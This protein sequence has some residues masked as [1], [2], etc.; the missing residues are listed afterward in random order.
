MQGRRKVCEGHDFSRVERV[1]RY[2]DILG[3]N[4]AVTGREQPRSVA[5]DFDGGGGGEGDRGGFG[6]GDGDFGEGEFFEAGSCDEGGEGFE[7]LE[8]G[9]FDDL[10]QGRALAGLVG[11]VCEECTGWY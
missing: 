5:G 2:C 8:G 1:G 10:G 9:W 3:G 6:D 11:C 4:V 7:G